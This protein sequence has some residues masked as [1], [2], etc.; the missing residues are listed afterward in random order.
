MWL[1]YL[2]SYIGNIEYTANRTTQLVQY[3]FNVN[4]FL[5]YTIWVQLQYISN[6]AQMKRKVTELRL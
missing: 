5:Y 1:H 2:R 3:P 4:N 6:S